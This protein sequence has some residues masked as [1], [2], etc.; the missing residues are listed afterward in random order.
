M[1]WVSAADRVGLTQQAAVK[2][3]VLWLRPP[4]LKN[5]GPR[6]SGPSVTNGRVGHTTGSVPR[7]LALLFHPAQGDGFL[8]IHLGFFRQHGLNELE[9]LIAAD[10]R[11][12]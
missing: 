5:G 6:C 11:L 9:N 4:P 3:W 1:A 12:G 7:A 8:I 2:L 10:T